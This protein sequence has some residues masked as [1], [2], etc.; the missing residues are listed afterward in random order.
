MTGPKH[1]YCGCANFTL[2]SKPPCTNQHG[3]EMSAEEAQLSAF[4][5]SGEDAIARPIEVYSEETPTP[6]SSQFDAYYEIDKTAC[7]ITEG[8][9]KRVC[10]RL[11]IG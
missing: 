9:Y 10:S 11:H 1:Q 2:S 7:W 8:G 5:T 4:S 3:S 6:G